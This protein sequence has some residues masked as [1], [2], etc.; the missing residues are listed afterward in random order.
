[1]SKHTRSAASAKPAKPYPEFP[2]TPHPTGR[3]R[4]KIRGKRWYFG[5]VKDGWE[6]ALR[7]YSKATTSRPGGPR[8]PEQERPA[9][10]GTVQ[11]LVA[12]Q[13]E[14]VRCWYG[15]GSPRPW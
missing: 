12:K 11:P 15:Q 10:A 4:K 3:W 9:S 2:L 1:M 13:R 7:T 6:T 8:G 5:K 14:L